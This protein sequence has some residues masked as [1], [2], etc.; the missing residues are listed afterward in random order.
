MRR[1]VDSELPPELRAEL[2]RSRRAGHDY[3]VLAK[4]PQLRAALDAAAQAPA[5]GSSSEHAPASQHSPLA[6]ARPHVAS[7]TVK[8]VLLAASFG[9]VVLVAW[10][11]LRRQASPARPTPSQQRVEPAAPPAPAVRAPEPSAAPAQPAAPQ[12]LANEVVAAQAEPSPPPASR[13][14]RRE[15]AQL[16]RIRALLERDPAAAY[17]LAQQSEREF[18]HGVLREERQALQVLALAKSGSMD[19]AERKA[20]AFFARYPQSPM[21][22]LLEAALHR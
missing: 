12:A 5:D 22:D 19:A 11:A 2:Q 21:R 10:P 8:L 18:P 6:R 4:L 15:I 7:S 14:S 9:A 20:Q 13:S 1:P 3:D 17:R 16:V